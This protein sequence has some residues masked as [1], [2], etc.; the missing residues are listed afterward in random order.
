MPGLDRHTASIYQLRSYASYQHSVS[1]P[2]IFAGERGGLYGFA[3]DPNGAV[4]IGYR[5]TKFTNPQ[6]QADG[7]A[8]S[9]PTTRWTR[10]P[11]RKIPAT[12]ANVIKDFVQ[13]FLPDLIPYETKT[14]LC[15]YTDS[16]DNHFVIDFVPGYKGLMVATG[17][18]G[19]GF[20]FLPTLGKHVVDLL[21]GRSNDYLHYW[22]W[23]SPEANKKPYNSIMEGI[24]SEDPFMSSYLLLK[25]VLQFGRVTCNTDI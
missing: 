10:Q 16:F 3:R 6:T 12:A 13:K 20:K 4:K 5:G 23:R 15:W 21:E 7:A 1:C 19:H 14:R 9:I 25:T 17:G 8:R 24:A 22:K 2:N 18:S 11:T